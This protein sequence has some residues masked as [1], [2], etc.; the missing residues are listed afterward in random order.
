MGPFIAASQ[1]GPRGRCCLP[2]NLALSS[3]ERGLWHFRI[4]RV[5]GPSRVVPSRGPLSHRNFRIEVVRAAWRQRPENN[6]ETAP[7]GRGPA[8]GSATPDS[9]FTQCFIGYCQPP[10][11]VGTKLRGKLR[12]QAARSFELQSDSPA[13]AGLFNRVDGPSFRWGPR[14]LPGALSIK[15]APPQRGMSPPSDTEIL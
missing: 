2:G 12:L 8:P 4:E 15:G 10:W 13:Q 3:P 7:G 14:N 5:P 9:A 6:P 1:G 11:T